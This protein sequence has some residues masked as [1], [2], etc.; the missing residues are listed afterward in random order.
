MKTLGPHIA[1]ILRLSSSRVSWE[2]RNR[3][4]SVNENKGQ[5]LRLREPAPSHH[6]LLVSKAAHHSDRA[7]ASRV[8]LKKVPVSAWN[9][10]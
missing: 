1:N 3:G 7:I 5:P 2:P 8:L 10:L 4:L 6:L 9:L